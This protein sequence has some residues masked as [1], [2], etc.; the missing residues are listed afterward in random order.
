MIVTK[1][2]SCVPARVFLPPSPPSP[3]PVTVTQKAC[4]AG[5]VVVWTQDHLACSARYPGGSSGVITPLSD[6]NAKTR[7]T[8]LAQCVDGKIETKDALCG[9]SEQA[10]NP[11]ASR[12]VAWEQG[13]SKCVGN[14]AGAPSGATVS[15]AGYGSSSRGSAAVRCL[16]GSVEISNAICVELNAVADCKFNEKKEERSSFGLSKCV[17]EFCTERAEYASTDVCKNWIKSH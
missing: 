13:A 6:T 9:T 8:V 2:E 5:I 10:P 7:G 11:C 4:N 14:F 16:N 15:V 12:P 17:R 1:D 3:P